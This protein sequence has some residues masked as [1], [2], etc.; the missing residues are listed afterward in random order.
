MSWTNDLHTVLHLPLTTRSAR[1]NFGPQPMLTYIRCTTRTSHSCK[2]GVSAVRNASASDPRLVTSEV[3]AMGTVP[4][5]CREHK[6][7]LSLIGSDD[8][9]ANSAALSFTVIGPHFRGETGGQLPGPNLFPGTCQNLRES[10]R[11]LLGEH[12][13]DLDAVRDSVWR[14][15]V[16]Q[17]GQYPKAAV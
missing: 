13:R 4:A 5:G 14:A 15:S 10:H 3:Y 7:V 1:A 8:L 11:R 17:A 6:F 9:I 12:D 2:F 16:W